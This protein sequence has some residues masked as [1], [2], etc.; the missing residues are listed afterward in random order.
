MRSPSTK[1]DSARSA[2]HATGSRRSRH[3]GLRRWLQLERLEDRQLLSILSPS[4]ITDN[5]GGPYFGKAQSSVQFSASASDPANPR[6]KFNYSWNFG[7]GTT[8]SGAS[9]V[10]VYSLDGLYRVT[11]NVQ[12]VGGGSASAATPAAISPVAIAGTNLTGNE[13]STFYFSGS[14]IGRDSLT[15]HWDFGDGGTADGSLT[16]SHV[17]VNPGTY[18]ATLTVA[19][20]S[21]LTGTTRLVATVNDVPPTVSLTNPAYAQV[22]TSV[23]FTASATALSPAVQAAGF[24][25]AWNFGDG[26]TGSG[27][28]LSH[29][30]TTAGTYT[31]TA[32]A[33]DVYGKVGTGSRTIKILGPLSVNAGPA[34]T[35]NAAA[36]LTFSQA[37]ESGGT[38]PFTYNWTFGDGTQPSGGL[39]PS[40]TYLNPGSY[41]ATVTVTDANML[42]NSSSVVVTVN[43][44]PPTVTYTDPPSVAGSPVSF[45]ASAASV[46]PAVQ[47]A[48]FT[49]AWNFGDKGTAA[50]ATVSHTYASA[51]TY[52]VTVSA[53]DMYGTT[54]T[55]SGT[56]TIVSAPVVSAGPPVTVN[57]ASPLTFSQATES[58]GTAPLTYNWD[59]GDGTQQSGSLNPSHTYQNPGSYTAMVTVTDANMLTDSS[60]VVVTVNDVAPT[61]SLSG[62]SSGAVGDSLSF[63]ATA[64]DVSP[65]VQAAGFTYNWNFGDGSTATAQGSTSAVAHTY[66]AV[67]TYTVSVTATDNYGEV[68]TAATSAL[69]ISAI[70]ASSSL[71]VSAGSNITTKEG[72]TVNFAGSVSGGTAP[73]TYSWN[74]GDGTSSATNT[75]STANSA[76]F[77]QTDTTTQGNWQG[78]YGAAGYNVIG[79]ASSYPS[80]AVVTP[81]G[82]SNWTWASSTTDV[83]AL[84]KSAAPT[85]RVAAC[86]S[87]STFFTVDVNLTDGHFHPVSL[88][89]LDWDRA[90]RSER[91]YMLDPSTF[92]VLDTRTLS[93][94]SGGEYLTWN[95]SG[96]VEFLVTTLASSN[97]VI[98]GLFIG[99][100]SGTPNGTLTPSHVYTNQGTYTA[101]L[102]ATDSAGQIGSSNVV[103]TVN[104]VPPTVTLNAP[105]SGTPGAPVSFSASATSPSPLDQAA[106]FTYTWNF[107][108][109]TTGTGGSPSHTYAAAGSY[110]VAV[111]AT[112]KDG[113]VSNA[114][115]KVLTIVTGLTGLTVSA[116]CSS[117]NT[118][119]TPVT[120][121][122]TVSGGTAPYTYSWNFGDNSTGS[123]ATPTHTYTDNGTYT[124]TLAVTDSGGQSSSSTLTVSV[125]N[126]PLTATISAP[127][128]GTVG[129][130]LSFTASATDPSPVDM[131]AGFTYAWA[132]GDGGTGTG[133][134]A[135]HIYTAAGTY[136]V[137]VTATDKDG[138]TSP[139]ATAVVTVSSHA[140]GISYY[141]AP[142][143]G[144]GAGTIGNPWGIS[145]LFS[146]DSQYY[147]PGVALSTLLPGDTLYFRGGSYALTGLAWPNSSWLQ[148]MICPTHNG[149]ALQPITLQAYP[150]EVPAFTTTNITSQ[151]VFG[152]RLSGLITSYVRV[153]GMKV[154]L[155][156][157]DNTQHVGQC[158]AV[159]FGG[160]GNEVGY[161]EVIGANIAWSDN[162]QGIDITSASQAWVHHNNV[163]DVLNTT[164]ANSANSAGIK[165][166]YSDHCLFED[167]YIHNCGSGIFDKGNGILNT[168]RRN[169][170]TGNIN[171]VGLTGNFIGNNNLPP[172]PSSTEYI[173]DNV[174]DGA[175]NLM[176]NGQNHQI[177]NN[178][179]RNSGDLIYGNAPLMFT[180]DGSTGS[181][182][183]NITAYNNIVLT[184]GTTPWGFFTPYQTLETVPPPLA[185]MD[186]N[187]YD[188]L[189]QYVF[190]FDRSNEFYTLSSIHAK[191]FETHAAVDSTSNIF[192][193]LTNYAV[194]T[195]YQTAG[196]YG[197]AV[198]PRVPIGG[199]GGIMDSS[200]YGP[201]ALNSGTTPGI[202]QQPQNQ[203]VASGGS[204]AFSIQ[205]SGS[206]L[207]FQWLRSNDSGSSWSI[208][209]GG[210]SA[211]LNLPQVSSADNNALFRC[212]VSSNGGSAWSNIATLTVSSA[213]ALSALAVPSSMSLPNSMDAAEPTA[214]ATGINSSSSSLLSQSLQSATTMSS[215]SMISVGGVFDSAQVTV[216]TNSA[217]PTSGHGNTTPRGPGGTF[218]D[219]PVSSSK[220]TVAL[221]VPSS[222]SGTELEL[223]P[224]APFGRQGR[225]L[226]RSKVRK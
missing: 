153:L 2:T 109:G 105:S 31:V 83:R 150:G 224:H 221:S 213:Q 144:S 92:A 193:D 168:F 26:T 203:T 205:V 50:G 133:A 11:L 51:G 79:D 73:Y 186:Y 82:Q 166:Y 134:T 71:T 121:T 10:H 219:S 198:G 77:V 127:S 65:A 175:I 184:Y 210:N 95:I 80:Y 207:Q 100:A 148:P 81:S 164:L 202:T 177:Y 118:E 102:T 113:A 181:V 75:A 199:T 117:N 165:I 63:T 226:V 8:G 120:F 67:G 27:A 146:T 162:H 215:P 107:G 88:Y 101:T 197:D 220:F 208:I 136:T 56:I 149:T 174:I 196:R 187:V 53:T 37:T 6:A 15:Y 34:L 183:S 44:V 115:T 190:D 99:G 129:S 171:G 191:G 90:G 147:Y 61:A 212:L 18:T 125:A 7:D 178:L 78:V 40:H 42:T 161:F 167:N 89:A 72:S 158:P 103:V 122:S 84:Q 135:T 119:G 217:T 160:T 91:V 59:F 152:G 64:T 25:Y 106:G 137:S 108:D 211:T 55:T 138:G 139:A 188:T 112:D 124:V 16:P 5:A 182:T 142:N 36:P 57:A 116:G 159:T 3:R 110:T 4:Q 123:G 23:A 45:T 170:L 47:S 58:G 128:S 20:T 151:P 28:S 141:V 96:H 60:S 114:A 140:A 29:S 49:Y 97:A 201:G 22:Q 173:Y 1:S 218:A 85:S 192:V 41:T 76:S 68:S 163:H 74:F 225:S 17:Y 38:A 143:V 126:V 87:G 206:G 66:A 189:P 24:T 157:W 154:T 70:S 94:F 214:N 43:D 35:V 156:P 172:F 209:Q 104:D 14:K 223:T 111:T 130:S 176:S 93:G 194:K 39:N 9:P 131:A 179:I 98:S 185:Y 169:F 86:W 54:G 52:T 132:F 180:T 204:A 69:T 216:A 21:G 46:S 155:G 33:T 13:A 200:R 30:F 195:A 48:G 145:D 32:S 222:Q 62:P 12:E 19:D